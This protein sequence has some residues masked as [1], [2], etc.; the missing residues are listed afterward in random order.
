[1][2]GGGGGGG[3]LRCLFWAGRHAQRMDI[4]KTSDSFFFFC[5]RGGCLG[6]C[7]GWSSATCLYSFYYKQEQYG[8]NTDVS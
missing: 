5:E 1:M 3:L 6:N 4:I 7:S 2:C 8:K